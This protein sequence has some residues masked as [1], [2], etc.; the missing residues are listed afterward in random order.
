M[1][2]ACRC[3]RRR[4]LMR[5]IIYTYSATIVK[6]MHQCRPTAA[7]IAVLCF[8][9]SELK[10][11]KQC[12]SGVDSVVYH[13][14][15]IYALRGCTFVQWCHGGGGDCS[16]WWR[17]VIAFKLCSSRVLVCCCYCFRGI[18]LWTWYQ[19]GPRC[20]ALSWCTRGGGEQRNVGLRTYPSSVCMKC[21]SMRRQLVQVTSL[22]DIELDCS[23]DNKAGRC[24]PEWPS[25]L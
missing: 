14:E 13:V 10:Y 15:L 1:H 2:F 17:Y 24:F 6:W 12:K 21:N 7:I 16:G 3:R 20:I 11:I 18:P 19:A 5:R 22:V 8:G 23:C 4:V 25:D 9:P